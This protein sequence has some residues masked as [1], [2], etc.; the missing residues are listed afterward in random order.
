MTTTEEQAARLAIADVRSFD[1]TTAGPRRR[2][3]LANHTRAWLDGLWRGATAGMRTDG[4]ALAAVGSLGRE[5]VPSTFGSAAIIS[6]SHSPFPEGSVL[7]ETRLNEEGLAV[8]EL[9]F[10]ALRESRESGDVRN[11]H[12]RS[13]VTWKFPA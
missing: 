4:V 11:W 9:D 7:A 1:D 3:A 6:P 10:D 8:A 12:D 5:P 2:A 13:P